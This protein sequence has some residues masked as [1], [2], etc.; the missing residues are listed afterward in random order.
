MKWKLE[1]WEWIFAILC[2]SVVWVRGS[3]MR[4]LCECCG[5]YDMCLLRVNPCYCLV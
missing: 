2:V 5:L 1:S 4:E 3:I